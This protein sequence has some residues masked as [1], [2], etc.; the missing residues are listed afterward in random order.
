MSV[1]DVV[2]GPFDEESAIDF[3]PHYWGEGGGSAMQGWSSD[4]SMLGPHF[5]RH[6]IDIPQDG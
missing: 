4:D 2:V 5:R 3:Q 1:G 6:N